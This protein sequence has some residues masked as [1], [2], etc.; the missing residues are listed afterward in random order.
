MRQALFC[1]VD[2][3][4][5]LLLIAFAVNLERV[6]PRVS[7]IFYWGNDMWGYCNVSDILAM[8]GLGMK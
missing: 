6:M 1:L 2:F 8:V 7:L 5:L 3:L 4:H